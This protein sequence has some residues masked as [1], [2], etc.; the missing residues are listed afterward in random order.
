M[1]KFFNVKN[2]ILFLFTSFL[3]LQNLNAQ[4][5]GINNTNPAAALDINGG[6]RLRG[7]TTLV[8]G[9]TVTLVS[10]KGYHFISGTP[11]GNFTNNFSPA[12]VEGQH[13][14][15]TN[16][17][18]FIGNVFAIAI[19]PSATVELF[20]SNGEWQQI[21][22]NGWGLTGNNVN[23]TLKFIGSTNEADVVFKRNSKHSGVLAKHNT[24]FGVGALNNRF[25][26]S[27]NTA[28]GDS[29]LADNFAGR[30]NTAIGSKALANNTYGESNTAT[31][32]GALAI[33]TLGFFHT[34]NGKDALYNNLFG[35]YNVAVGVASLRANTTG[36]NNTSLGRAA[37]N[38]NTTGYSNV[39]AGKIQYG[40]F[41]DPAHWL[42]IV[43]GGTAALGGDRV[44]KLWSEG[45]LRIKGNALPDANNTYS[46]GTSGQRWS[47]VWTN[48][49]TIN[50]S[51]ANLKTN[52]TTSPYGLSEVMQMN[53]VQYNWK[54]NP[55]EDLQIG[56][57]A[58]D[59]QKIIPEAVVVPENG[60]P[61]G[62]KYTELI[63]VLVKAIQELKQEN[64]QYK[65]RIEELEAKKNNE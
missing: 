19:P 39:D 27:F 65:K 28:I 47:S 26:S 20:Y 48:A 17:T 53:P 61:L 6:I 55:N 9:T 50:T 44:I 11:T 43:G 32:S 8:S 40:G 7:S 46:L 45:G 59:I 2:N 57:L 12:P 34:A 63:P 35:S 58:Q 14:I 23:S 24:S 15:I 49:G 30:D 42:A 36:W 56:F 10:N 37:M 33:N 38:Q 41:G 3:V 51:D 21:G 18:T 60:D 64:E 4:N 54:T 1:Y 13:T 31:G 62:M 25:V 16:T 29:A 22:G 5:V 52:I